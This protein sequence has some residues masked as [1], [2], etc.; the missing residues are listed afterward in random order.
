MVSYSRVAASEL[1]LL[2]HLA[3]RCKKA[4]KSLYPILAKLAALGQTDS[5]GRTTY[6][7]GVVLLHVSVVVLY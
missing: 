5:S 3:T 4:S 1:V 2:Q 7:G 6:L